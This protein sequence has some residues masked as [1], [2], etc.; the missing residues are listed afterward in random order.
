MAKKLYAKRAGL[1]ELYEA[2]KGESESIDTRL[3]HN[4]LELRVFPGC[5]SYTS[6]IE[7][8]L[9]TGY[10]NPENTSHFFMTILNSCA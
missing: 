9:K 3:F 6:S 5:G 8:N 2:A 7:L 10:C 4:N 1:Y